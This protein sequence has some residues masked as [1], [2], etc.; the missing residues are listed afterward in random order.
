[1]PEYLNPHPHDLYLVGPDG[2]TV[3]IRK[4]RRVRLPEFFDRYVGKDG[5]V[6]GYL[7]NVEKLPTM[8]PP[9]RELK[10]SRPQSRPIQLNKITPK[11]VKRPIVGRMRRNVDPSNSKAFTN[12]AYAISNGIGIGIL[13]YNRP[14]SLRRLLN[15]IFK[16]TDTCRTTIFI[17]DDGSTDQEQLSYL[18]ELEARDDIVIIRNQKQLGVA[19]NSNR[20]IRCLSRFPK[21]ILLNDDVEILNSGWENF[22]F[23]AMSRTDF[24]HFCYRQPGVYGATKGDNVVVHGTLLNIVGSKPHGAVM[25][26]DH[27]AFA[28]VGYFDEQFGQ[29][30]VEHVDWS[31]RL[32]ESKLQQPG[33][34]D[35][36]GSS[37]YFVVHPEPSSVENRV[38][39]FKHAKAILSSIGIR[40]T[41]INASEAT[42]VPCISCVIPF[43]EINR[44]D[45][46]LTV[47][48]SIRAQRYP[49]IEIIMTEEDSAMKTKDSDFAPARHVFTTG[50]PGAAFNKSRAWNAGVEACTADIL[51]LHDADT[52]APS[53]YFKAVAKE[54]TDAESCHLCKNIFYL[55]SQATHTVNT[56]GIVNRPIYDHMVD[57]FEGGTIACTRKAYWKIGGFVEEFVGYGV[58]DCDFYFRLSKATIWKENRYID[59][60]HLHHARVDNWITFHNRNK[61]LGTKIN[62]LS[63]NDRIARQRQLLIQSGRSRCLE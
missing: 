58:E 9:K 11:E 61:E 50:L 25:A 14:S 36:D 27:I 37:A 32:S 28:K 18:S 60:L 43:R 45:S 5:G 34:F 38:E 1:V 33:F 13:T 20:L 29:Y 31:N 7:V 2:N 53:S 55:G 3:H 16:Y 40:P 30:G 52:L 21:K 10:T 6:R 59:L 12:N 26:F 8:P 44:K 41:Y 51:I 57:Y 42:V 49:D 15:S 46:I 48:G 23:T 47:L 17:S 35:V 19:G 39:K 63:L 4:G 56:T 62:S 22:Y 54:L 24:H